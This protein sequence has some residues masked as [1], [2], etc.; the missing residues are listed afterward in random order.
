MGASLPRSLTTGSPGYPNTPEKQD[1]FLSV[2]EHIDKFLKEIKRKMDQNLEALTRQTQE[3]LRK[4]QENM[5][6]KT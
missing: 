2:A 4:I 5:D 6:Q 1:F 3:P